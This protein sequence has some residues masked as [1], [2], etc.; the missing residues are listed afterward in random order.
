MPPRKKKAQKQEPKEPKRPLTEAELRR[1]AELREERRIA[2]E[3]KR[4][5][6]MNSLPEEYK[7]RFLEVG[8]A[9]HGKVDYPVLVMNPFDVPPGEGREIW[10]R[11]YVANKARDNLSRMPFIFYWYGTESWNGEK[12]TAQFGV[13]INVKEKPNKQAKDDVGRAALEEMNEYLD[14]ERKDRLLDFEV[15][16]KYQSLKDYELLLEAGELVDEQVD[17]GPTDSKKATKAAKR[18][19]KKAPSSETPVK[20]KSKK[21][22]APSPHGLFKAMDVD[23]ADIA[24]PEESDGDVPDRDSAA[25]EAD[26]ALAAEDAE[27]SADDDDDEAF[28]DAEPGNDEPLEVDGTNAKQA[29]TPGTGG[30]TQ[31][32]KKRTGERKY[33]SELRKNEIAYKHLW[34]ELAVAIDGK[35]VDRVEHLLGEVEEKVDDFSPWFFVL[36][37]APLFKSIKALYAEKNTPKSDRYRSFKRKMSEKYKEKSETIKEGSPQPEPKFTL[38]KLKQKAAKRKSADTPSTKAL[39]EEAEGIVQLDSNASH[40]PINTATPAEKG[41]TSMQRAPVFHA[42]DEEKA[43]ITGSQGDS[44]HMASPS[45]P[46]PKQK[47]KKFSLG[48]FMRPSVKSEEKETKVEDPRVPSWAADRTSLDRPCHEIR[49]YAFEF[50]LEMTN[51]LP[52]DR[53]DALSM[54]IELEHAIFSWSTSQVPDEARGDLSASTNLADVYWDKIHMVAAGM[55]GRAPG[56]CGSITNSLLMGSYEDVNE[57][58]QLSRKQF[59]ASFEGRMV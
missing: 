29:S 56:L 22:S 51:N 5:E 34:T 12:S 36:Y 13:D 17:G 44:T 45:K 10:M 6:I 26:E 21:S 14:K 8:Y 37:A 15:T 42:E 27:A 11:R 35:Q 4:D 32:K 40:H 53:V 39:P 50:L 47:V 55:E 25:K 49:T 7:A 2:F 28:I 20:K 59:M 23:M 58:V 41:R 52:K 24:D 31:K 18:K 9:A 54:A 3:T 33:I 16:E 30:R 57:L 48:S 38:Y 43:S 46:Q 19:K 1:A